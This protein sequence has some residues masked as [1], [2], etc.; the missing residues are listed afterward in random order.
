MGTS[1]LID[2]DESIIGTA[3]AQ[4]VPQRKMRKAAIGNFKNESLMA[5]WNKKRKFLNIIL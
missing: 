3:F 2:L 4:F 1:F 5:I